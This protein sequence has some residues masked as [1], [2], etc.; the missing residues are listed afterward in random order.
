MKIIKL[1]LCLAVN[2]WISNSYSQDQ[3]NYYVFISSNIPKQSLIQILEQSKKINAEV[4]L[5]GFINDSHKVTTEIFQDLINMTQYGVIVDPELF[6]KYQ[7]TQVPTFVIAKGDKYDKLAGNISWQEA[8]DTITR[9][10]EVY[11]EQ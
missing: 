10:G 7:I 5:R 11:A 3:Y 4:V 1:T 6:T 2:I 9:K 8:I